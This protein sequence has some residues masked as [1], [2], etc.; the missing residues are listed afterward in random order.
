MGTQALAHDLEWM[1]WALGAP[2]ISLLGESYGTRAAAAYAS[3]FPNQVHRVAVTGVMAPIPDRFDYAKAAAANTAMILGF[4][5][6]QCDADPKCTENPWKESEVL[7]PGQYFTGSANQAVD[8][9]FRRSANGGQWY[10]DHCDGKWI[11][12][13]ELSQQLQTYLT[14]IKE[15]QAWIKGYD[16][17]AW[18]MG[19]LVLP[20]LVFKLV[21]Y[22]CVFAGDPGSVSAFAQELSIFNLI[23]ALDMA[24][25]WGK[26]Q[27]LAF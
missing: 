24:G 4:I 12:T 22:P 11:S 16:Q 20:A 8:E 5:Q 1:R 9:L 21:M 26:N 7:P 17:G 25:K 10:K 3:Q 23:P 15:G 19:F 6:E 27:A 13:L 14:E 2:Q 18:P